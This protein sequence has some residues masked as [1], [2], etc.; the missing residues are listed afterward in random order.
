M[1][2]NSRRLFLKKAGVGVAALS[3]RNTVFI[4]PGKYSNPAPGNLFFTTGCKTA[5]VTPTSA[6]LWTRLCGQ[7][8]P[9]PVKHQRRE[10]VF[11][12]PVDFDENRPVA[13]MDGAVQ[14]APGQVRATLTRGAKRIRSAWY[15]AGAE[16]DFTVR[17]PFDT[18]KPNTEYQ[19]LWEARPNPKGAISTTTTY[20]TT[21]PDEKS[22][23]PI[24]LVTS[25]C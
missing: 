12:H 7:E 10:R 18:L 8:K 2:S 14:G 17:V 9:N 19:V 6:I 15:E 4:Q 11:R 13:E 16:Q 25:T 20:F 3:F 23:R 21:A 5:E 1:K 24:Q 22:S